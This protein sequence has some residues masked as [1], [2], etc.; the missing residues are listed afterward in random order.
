MVKMKVRRC[1]KCGADGVKADLG[2]AWFEDYAD[3]LWVPAECSVCG[4]EYDL[5]LAFD[6]A[7]DPYE[8]LYV[9]A[10]DSVG[11]VEPDF[12]GMLEGVRHA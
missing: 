8:E 12:E 10:G 2:H 7:M 4:F 3:E 1:P 11:S 5:I 6:R 9:E